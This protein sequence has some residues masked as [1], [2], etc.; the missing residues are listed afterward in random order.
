MARRWGSEAEPSFSTLKKA[1]VSLLR[2]RDLSRKRIDVFTPEY[3]LKQPA[4]SETTA[5]RE[6]STSDFRSST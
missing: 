2:A 4:G 5:T 3:G 6:F 1:M